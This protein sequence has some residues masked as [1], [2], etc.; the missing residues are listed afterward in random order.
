MGIYRMTSGR[1]R[2]FE[3]GKLTEYVVGDLV[4]LDASEATRLAR[5]IT[6]VDQ[7]AKARSPSKD[8]ALSRPVTPELSDGS[9][10][11][12]PDHFDGEGP[13]AAPVGT[14]VFTADQ[15]PGRTVTELKKVIANV[16]EP[17]MLEDM[18]DVETGA[19]NRRTVLHLLEVR[20]EE[21]T[22][23]DEPEE[24]DED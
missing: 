12:D 7:T 3:K 21:L 8:E 10:D 9:K 13:G 17:S 15:T 4:D 1:Y 5:L 23:D 11:T 2:R 24:G 14:P 20:R 6:P 18:M 22:D 16:G 19:A